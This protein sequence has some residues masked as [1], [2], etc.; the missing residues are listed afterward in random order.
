MRDMLSLCC[1]LADAY[2]TPE[3]DRLSKV[4]YRRFCED[5][6][7][8]TGLHFALCVVFGFERCH[9]LIRILIPQSSSVQVLELAQHQHTF[10]LWNTENVM[11]L[12]TP[13]CSLCTRY[14]MARLP[15]SM[16]YVC[17]K[18]CCPHLLKH[19]ICHWSRPQQ[20][21][22]QHKAQSAP[23]S[24]CPYQLLWLLCKVN[25]R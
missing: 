23:D 9:C 24:T 3:T 21:P 15:S 6:N 19:A 16:L 10:V 4:D 25:W 5:I 20:I 12:A 13:S 17:I 22:A 14:C 11:C 8:G 2:K 1:R 18:R 7:T